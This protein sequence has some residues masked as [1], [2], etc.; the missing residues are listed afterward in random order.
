MVRR[1]EGVFD[2]RYKLLYFYDLDEWEFYD[3]E[4]DTHEM[5]SEY[6]NPDYAEIVER[7]KGELARLK[8]EYRVPPP[9]PLAENPDA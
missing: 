6:D 1:H 4:Q 5:K 9:E 7:L 3:T 2:G 8:K